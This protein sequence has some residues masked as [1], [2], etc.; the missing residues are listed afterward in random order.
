MS[1]SPRQ[2]LL[3]ASAGVVKAHP[4]HGVGI[5]TR[6][7]NVVTAYVEIVPTDTVK[8]ELDKDSG[9]L[10]VDRP[11]QFSNM[12]PTLYGLVPQ[13]YCAER[14]AEICA[15]ATG[16]DDVVGDGDPLDVCILSETPILHSNVLL[17]CVPIGGLRMIDRN[18][19]DDKIIAVLVGDGVYGEWRDINECP[20]KFIERLMHYFLTYK[21]VP[22]RKSKCEI[23]HVYGQR[24]ACDV[25]CRSHED[26]VAH[27][28]HIHQPAPEPEP[29][30]A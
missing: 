26:Y 28:G 3:R 1:E 14:T 25:I 2:S 23:T 24:T 7:P 16:R 29:E 22:G 30:P 21:D 8:Y 11:Q 13:T 12:C 19:A 15:D 4:W 5:G 27:F 6:A 17:N 18:E 9:I 10:R 20:N